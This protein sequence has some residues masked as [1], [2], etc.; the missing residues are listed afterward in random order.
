MREAQILS[1]QF[2][3]TAME[4]LPT[5]EVAEIYEILSSFYLPSYHSLL[6]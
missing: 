4:N 2:V 6:F 5:Y 3:K 1:T